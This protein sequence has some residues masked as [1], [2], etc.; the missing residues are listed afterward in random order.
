MNLRSGQTIQ[1]LP[2]VLVRVND[3]TVGSFRRLVQARGIGRSDIDPRRDR[4][5]QVADADG[6]L[7]RVRYAARERDPLVI[8]EEVREHPRYEKF[9]GLRRMTRDPQRQ[10]FV[11]AA[12]VIRE[13]DV[14]VV[15]GCLQ[16]HLPTRRW[17]NRRTDQQPVLW[18][19]L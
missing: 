18:R 4:A 15:D 10:R 12:I 17:F 7:V 5:G 1:E 14:E 9:L 2:R 11:D 16:R 8:L 13:V 19:D 6:W 3:D